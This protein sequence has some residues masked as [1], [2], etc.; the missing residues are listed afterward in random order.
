MRLLVVEDEGRIGDY[1]QQGL[2]EAG[3]VVDL[4][5][6]GSDGQRLAMTEDYD[7]MVLDETLAEVDGRRIVQSLR[8][9]GRCVPVLLL[10]ECNALA[11]GAGE[12]EPG[13]DGYLIKPFSFSELLAGVRAMLRRG[14]ML[15][16][17]DRLEAADLVLDLAYR[18][19][20][21]AG[22]L[23]SLTPDEFALLELLMRSQG[24]VLPRSLI[25]A[26]VWG[27][28][29]DCDSNAVDIAVRRLQAKIDDG[30]EPQLVRTVRA[31]G[32]VLTRPD[33]M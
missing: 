25:A 19:A 6:N 22:R 7:L 32:Y 12:F 2:G 20:T 1:L 4:V 14:D 27:M 18:L 16:P 5:D 3:F 31:M 21:R 10:T 17:C 33:K 30:F 23:V 24:E 13:K 9:A 29:F 26:R 8:R 15:V 28:S 11:R